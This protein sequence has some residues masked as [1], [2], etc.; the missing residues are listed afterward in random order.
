MTTFAPASLKSSII[1]G[2]GR[3]ARLQ[4]CASFG[5]IHGT[6]PVLATARLAVVSVSEGSAI[7]A[8]AQREG[9]LVLLLSFRGKFDGLAAFG[10]A[11]KSNFI[12]LERSG[13]SHDDFAAASLLLALEL[14]VVALNGPFFD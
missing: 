2:S 14:D 1:G 12:A 10:L 3:S 7:T 9:K 8:L 5:F 6:P 11:G 13:P 4:L